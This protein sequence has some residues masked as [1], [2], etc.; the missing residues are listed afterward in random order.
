VKRERNRITVWFPSPPPTSVKRI[1]QHAD[2]ES[3]ADFLTWWIEPLLSQSQM[4]AIRAVT[5]FNNDLS[6]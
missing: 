1:L 4:F 2:Y 6:Q 3:S 5:Q